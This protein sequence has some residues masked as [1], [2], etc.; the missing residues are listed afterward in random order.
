MEFQL[1]KETSKTL[2]ASTGRM[3]GLTWTGSAKSVTFNVDDG[4]GNMQ[5]SGVKVKLSGIT[6]IDTPMGNSISGSQN[7]AVYTLSGQKVDRH[8]MKPGLYLSNGKKF[9]VR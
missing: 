1:A 4:S 8:S 3:N 2:S 6:G 9:V 7:D 5:L